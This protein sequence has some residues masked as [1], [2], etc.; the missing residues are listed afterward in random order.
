[1]GSD[2]QRQIQRR[3]LGCG[4]RG[5]AVDEP[6]PERLVGPDRALGAKQEEPEE[7][8]EP[9]QA[10]IVTITS[11][12]KD[13]KNTSLSADLFQPPAGYTEKPLQLPGS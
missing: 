1:M 7:E 4:G 10:V 6:E 12:T 13:M 8:A 3:F 11:E 5:D 9:T 2:A